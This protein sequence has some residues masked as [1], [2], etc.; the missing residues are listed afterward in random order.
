MRCR[1]LAYQSIL[2]LTVT[3]RHFFAFFSSVR[4]A[5][6]PPLGG[7]NIANSPALSVSGSTRPVKNVQSACRSAQSHAD[8]SHINRSDAFPDM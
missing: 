2:T 3:R 7:K 5:A 1:H 4:P 8:T 6:Y